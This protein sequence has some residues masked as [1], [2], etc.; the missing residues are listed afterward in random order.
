MYPVSSRFLAALTES[1][2]PAVEVVLFRADGRV[3]TLEVTGGSVTVDRGQAIRRTCTVAIADTALI[4]RTPADK[5]SVYGA[6]LRISRGVQYG[7]G[8]KELVPLGVFRLDSVEGDVDEGPVTL[9]G[10]A[11]E[12]VVQ[13]DRFTAP[14]RASGTAVGAVTALIQRS[15]PDAAVVNRATDATIGPRTWD[16]EGDPWA[17]VQECAAAIGAEVYCDAD[18]VFVIAEL[19]DLLTTSPAWTVAAGEGGAYIKADRGMTSDKVYNGVLAR[20]ENTESNTAP[21]A[22]LVVDDDATSPTFWDGP[23]GH[24]PT[25]YTSSTLTSSVAAEGAARLKLR[26]TKSPNSSGDLSSL[27]NP[28]LEPGDVIRVVYPDGTREL[29]QIQ[30]LSVPLDVG[31]DF[32]ITTIA[33][34]EDA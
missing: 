26:A 21:V 8:V 33:A 13:D 34:K 15:I 28:A 24:R 3:E 31:G 32:P 4:P 5:L 6:R 7:D 23:F 12:A 11:L 16:V 22:A 14:Y 27:P 9:T 25:F 1:H 20:G 17:A 29:H 2:T 19:P 30:S 18:G 10:K